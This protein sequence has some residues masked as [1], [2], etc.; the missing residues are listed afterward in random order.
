MVRNI[1]FHPLLNHGFWGGE[2]PQYCELFY[3]ESVFFLINQAFIQKSQNIA[4][5][6]SKVNAGEAGHFNIHIHSTWHGGGDGS[7]LRFSRDELPQTKRELLRVIKL[8]QLGQG[9]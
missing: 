6:E 9:Q 5:C 7:T 1:W 3:L 4:P 2:Q 8:R